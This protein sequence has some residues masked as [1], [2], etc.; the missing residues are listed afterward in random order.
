MPHE[1]DEDAE[2]AVE[3]GAADECRKLWSS[4]LSVGIKWAFQHRKPLSGHAFRQ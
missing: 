1:A 3:T 4:V 2:H